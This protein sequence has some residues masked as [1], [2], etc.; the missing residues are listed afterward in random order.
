M[1]LGRL[2]YIKSSRLGDAMLGMFFAT[3]CIHIADTTDVN[4]M[5]SFEIKNC[6]RLTNYLDFSN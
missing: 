3:S 5:V 4:N 2:V 1:R 6:S